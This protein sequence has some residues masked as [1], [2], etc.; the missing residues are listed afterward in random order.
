MTLNR[1]TEA[2]CG[3]TFQAKDIYSVYSLQTL[4]G[5]QF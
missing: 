4:S 3:E 5:N 1:Q 2:A